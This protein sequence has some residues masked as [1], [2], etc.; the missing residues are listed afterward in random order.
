MPTPPADPAGGAVP[1]HW[2]RGAF[3]LLWVFLAV[4]LALLVVLAWNTK[5]LMDEYWLAGRVWL[6][7][8]DLYQ[9]VFPPKTLLYAAFYQLA[10]WLGEGSVQIMQI[11]RLQAVAA[12]ILGLGLLYAIAR[13][14]GRGRLEALFALCVVLAFSSYMER[15]FMTRP[16]APATFLALAALWAVTRE[17]GSLR[18]VFIAGLLSGLAFLIMQKSVYFNLAL[19]LALVGEGLTRRSLK[20]A[21]FAGAV[22]VLGW[23]LMVLAYGAY[24]TA[25]GA[26]FGDVLAQVFT[27]SAGNVLRGHTAYENLRIYLGQTFSRNLAEYLLCLAGWLIV[28]PRLLKAPRAE[29]IAWIFTGVIATLIYLHPAPWP[30]N[31]IMAIPF[32]GLWAPLVAQALARRD[33]G[34]SALILGGL[35]LALALSVT[36]NVGYLDN[37]NGVQNRTVQRAEALLGPGGTY[38][39]GI[40]MVVTRRRAGRQHWWA[41]FGILRILDDAKRGEFER[42]DL[43]FADS[44]KLWILNYRTDALAGVLKP[45]FENAYVPIFPNILITG[46][47]LLPGRDATFQTRWPGR[48]RLYRADGTPAEASVVVDGRTVTGDVEL[49]KG[50]HLLRLADV[51]GSLYLLPA[52]IPVP[53]DLTRPLERKPLFDKVYT[54]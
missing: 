38:A 7:D 42:I 13:N 40:G 35:T 28:V 10:H 20:D 19:G 41:R 54:F 46:L 37:H 25:T 3:A 34:R 33:A 50:R 47:E 5:F 43:V 51:Q 44:P 17:R 32:L 36:R 31:F 14:I 8:T 49:E 24:F 2:R 53:F 22:L 16:E 1:V 29:R 45:Y 26:A 30:Y 21:V 27:G 48:Y 9:S 4:K 11:A 23:A 52:D 6:F 18:A 39:D 15:A 12:S